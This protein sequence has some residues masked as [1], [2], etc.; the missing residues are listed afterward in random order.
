[1]QRMNGE[2]M[3]W[4]SLVVAL[5]G[6]SARAD[7][8]PPPAKCAP[9]PECTTCQ[10]PDC[11]AAALDGGLIQSDCVD[12]TG[13]TSGYRDIHYFCPPGVT[14]SRLHTCGCASVEAAVAALLAV[15]P[16]LRR[17]RRGRSAAREP[18]GASRRST[19]REPGRR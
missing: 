10:A 15:T 2:V 18:S 4:A 19:H 12:F 1:M 6:A 14:V 9:P 17:R 11:A 7:Y 13:T 16:L 3:R 5:L 8:A